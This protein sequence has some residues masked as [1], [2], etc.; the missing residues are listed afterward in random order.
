MFEEALVQYYMDHIHKQLSENSS[1]DDEDEP[2]PSNKGN[3]SWLYGYWSTPQATEKKQRKEKKENKKKKNAEKTAVL[4][5]DVV[6]MSQVS[7]LLIKVFRVQKLQNQ[8]EQNFGIFRIYDDNIF[9]GSDQ[10]IYLFN[11]TT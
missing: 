9:V 2:Q 6:Y 5:V 11:L 8:K 4:D 3:S 10:K 7:N 1:S